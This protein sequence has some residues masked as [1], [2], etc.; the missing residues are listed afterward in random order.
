MSRAYYSA[1][2]HTDFLMA[3]LTWVRGWLRSGIIIII[4]MKGGKASIGQRAQGNVAA[5]N[6]PA[7]LDCHLHT[8][9]SL[10]LACKAAEINQ[11]IEPRTST[12]SCGAL[13]IGH[14]ADLIMQPISTCKIHRHKCVISQPHRQTPEASPSKSHHSRRLVT[15]P[16]ALPPL[17][18][19]PCP[20]PLTPLPP[21]SASAVRDSSKRTTP[22]AMPCRLQDAGRIAGRWTCTPAG[23]R[24]RLLKHWHPAQNVVLTGPETVD[25]KPHPCF[26]SVSRGPVGFGTRGC[27]STPPF[28]SRE[29]S[30][31]MHRSGRR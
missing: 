13:H 24:K 19:L 10:L 2:L 31:A 16:P 8:L 28:R 17:P 27:L 29:T 9:L 22:L 12:V 14:P 30:H 4:I 18:S 21:L 6:R 25:V 11:E 5:A 15:I 20:L 3:L 7:P 26:V 1:P 23:V